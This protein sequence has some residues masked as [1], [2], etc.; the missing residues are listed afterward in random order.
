M[1]EWDTL[2]IDGNV[3]T[4][5]PQTDGCGQLIDAAVAVSGSQIAWVGPRAELPGHPDRLATTV[6]SLHGGWLTPGLI[7]AHTHLVFAGDRVDEF[8]QRQQGA[9]YEDIARAGGGVQSTVSATRAADAMQLLSSASRRARLM[10]ERGVTTLEIK[11]GYGLNLET[12][13]RMLQTARAL[14]QKL[15]LSVCSTFLG[16]HALPD[17]FAG[18]ADDYIDCVC[19]EM[20]P[21]LAAEGLVDA[22]DAFCEDIAFSATQ[23]EKVFQ[24]AARLKLPIKLHADQLS[25]NGGAELAARYHALSADHLEYTSEAGVRAMAQSGTVAVLLPGAFY[26]LGQSQPPP[27]ELFRQHGVPIAV[28]SDCNPGSSPSLSLPMMM[29]MACH[30][31]GLTPEESLAGVT[32]VA[33][34]ALGLSDRGMIE[35]GKRADMAIWDVRDPAEL[36]YWIGASPPVD[37]IVGGHSQQL[38]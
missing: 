15:P 32:R 10:L 25:D 35:A 14:E 11:S 4:M 23:T 17:E 29:N 7:D 27:V 36:S 31:F 28:A 2:W 1:P 30:L 34:Q 24:C 6:V 16:A 18:R 5:A 13:R 38:Q 19:D 37:V 20:M 21:A 33:A 22:V 26:T 8:R 3:A 12:E 9:S